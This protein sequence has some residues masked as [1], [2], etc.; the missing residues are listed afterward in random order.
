MESVKGF[1][2]HCGNTA[3][4]KLLFSH[5][6]QSVGYSS[7][8][9]KDDEGPS[10]TYYAA[11]CATCGDLLLYHSFCHE[12]SEYNFTDADLLHPKSAD[13]NQAVPDVVRKCYAEAAR[14]QNTA[15]NAYAVMIR[16]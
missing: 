5:S 8:G 10:C 14:I 16:R 11:E 1:C 6:Y 9:T 15:P 13:L 4:Q 7:D 3:P 2:P 12:H